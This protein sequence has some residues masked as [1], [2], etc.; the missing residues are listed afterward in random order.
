MPSNHTI[1]EQSF[2]SKV[3]ILTTSLIMPKVSTNW[4]CCTITY[5]E[6]KSILQAD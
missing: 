2:I 4:K 1:I 6:E 5:F 3:P